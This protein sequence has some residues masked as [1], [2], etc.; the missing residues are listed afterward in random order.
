MSGTPKQS[1]PFKAE[2]VGSLL[3]PD[4]LVQ[5]RY[6]VAEGKA[7][8]A[9]LHPLEE[10]SITEVVKMQQECGLHVISSGEYARC[11]RTDIVVSQAS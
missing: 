3:R 1:P 5:M 4:E 8:D 9:E 7:T 11:V 6:K 10:K 2:H